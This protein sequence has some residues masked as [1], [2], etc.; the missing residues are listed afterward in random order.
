[1]RHIV[2]IIAVL[3]TAFAME[4]AEI[5]RV[6]CV[7]D[8]ITAARNGW[9]KKL[10]DMDSFETLNGGRSGQRAVR[11]KEQLTDA[12]AKADK[13][14]FKAD[15]VILFLGV[16]DLPARDKRP[17]DVKVGICVYGM[18]EAI[19]LAV[20]HFKPQ[21]IIVLAPCDVNADAMNKVN[22]GKGYD[23]AKPLLT[24]LEGGYRKLATKRGVRFHS[25]LKVVSQ[26]NYTDGLHPNDAG[27]EQIAE[28]LRAFLTGAGKD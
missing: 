23:K 18:N 24:K 27:H 17:G 22:L 9:V 1:M 14:G 21:D 7:G 16:N 13:A 28:S 12:L 3:V 2:A 20:K 25:L 15:R 8:S 10:G 5:Q 26:E 11:A 4:A 19:D 6:L